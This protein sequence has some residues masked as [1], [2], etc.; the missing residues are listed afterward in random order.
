MPPRVSVSLTVCTRNGTLTRGYTLRSQWYT[1]NHDRTTC[2][3]SGPALQVVRQVA[4]HVG[5]IHFYGGKNAML[6]PISDKLAALGE[7]GV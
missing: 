3:E 2:N 1:R 4:D 5:A 6:I 7:C